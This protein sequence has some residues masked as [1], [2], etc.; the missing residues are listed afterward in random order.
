MPAPT[1]L[2]VDLGS[3]SG[4][5]IAGTLADGVVS[6]VE[7]HRFAHQASMV[8]GY[9]SWDLDLIWGEIVTGLR[10]AVRQF[11][12]AG[13]VS[14]DTW[15]VDYV[16]VDQSGNRLT[17]GRAYRDERTARTVDAFRERLSDERAWALT[18]IAPAT[19]NSANQLF[20]YLTEEPELAAATDQ[21]LFLPDYFT[22]L[23][24]GLRGWSRSHVSTSG[25][26]APGAN[27]WA[28]EVFD[29]LG[30]P[31]TWMGELAAEHNVAGP[32]TVE[33]LEQLTV[34][35]AGAHDTACAVHALQRAEGAETYFLSCGSWSVLGV[36][37]D[38][39]LMS[40]EARSLGLTNE[41]RGDAGVRPLFNITGLWI[42]QECQRNWAA[43]GDESNIVELLRLARE[44]DSL[45]LVI[46]PD[47]PQYAAPGGMVERVTAALRTQGAPSEISQG[48]VVLA[49]LESFAARYARGVAD[50]AALTG[51]PATQLNLVGGGSRNELLCDLTA[52]ALGVPVVAG[53]AEASTLGSLLAQFEIMGHLDPADRHDVIG[54]TAST[55]RH[56]P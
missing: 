35:R 25:L 27:Q 5:I 11:P 7:I 14:V 4:R 15:G 16:P 22:F 3:S 45:G 32:C 47:E 26:C 55:R 9:L 54:A 46:D 39:P 8:D 12:A 18:G 23:L 53:P 50:L 44:A 31:R 56:L 34:V 21:V 2:A 49:I 48:Q 37:R 1:A 10:E 29:A 40:E 30:I 52:K 6:E 42:L 33:G 20:A 43:A 19:I 13:S 24:S 41:A 51:S 17:P 36:L 38:E 28:T